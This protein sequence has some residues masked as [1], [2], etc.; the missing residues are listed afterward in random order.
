MELYLGIDGGGTRTTAWLVNGE[1]ERVGQ[2]EAGPSNPLKVGFG[3]ATREITKAFQRCL[4]QCGGAQPRSKSPALILQAV[5]A[6]IA[7]TDRDCVRRPLLAWMRRDIP[8]HRH[9]L[10]TDAAIALCAAFRNSPGILVISGTGSIAYGRNA[11]GEIMR[12]G[13][14][15]IPF[16]DCG[17]G[18]DIGRKAV[19]AAL[20]A[21]DGRGPQTMLTALVCRKLKLRQ[22]NDVVGRQLEPQQI[23]EVFPLVITAAKKRDRVAR[24]LCD[25]AARDLVGLA[26]TLMKKSGSLRCQELVA[27]TGG[28]FT[29]GNSIHRAFVRELHRYAPRAKVEML[30]NLPVEGAIWL[31]RYSGRKKV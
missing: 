5:C 6:G 17:S 26:V 4:K 19:A 12:T 15:G 25:S 9:L 1:G 16:D 8:A 13:G 22:I 30:K 24:S 10:T 2:A 27:T 11:K 21:F 28:V 14:W 18:Y 7:G 3:V 29:S 31:A 23:A 20:Q